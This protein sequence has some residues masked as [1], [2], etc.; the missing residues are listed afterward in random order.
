MSVTQTNDWPTARRLTACMM[1]CPN[2]RLQKR[3]CPGGGGGCLVRAQRLARRTSAQLCPSP[4]AAPTG[5]AASSAGGKNKRGRDP[6]KRSHCAAGGPYWESLVSIAHV[7]LGTF[8]FVVVRCT[9]ELGRVRLWFWFRVE[10][11]WSASAYQSLIVCPAPVPYRQ[12]GRRLV[13]GGRAD[14]VADSRTASHS[15]IAFV[16][17]VRLIRSSVAPVPY[18]Q[19]GRRLVMGGR[20]DGVA[21]SCT[22]SHSAIAFVNRVRLIRSSV[23][24]VPYRQRGH[25]LDD[26]RTCPRARPAAHIFRGQRGSQSPVVPIL[27]WTLGWDPGDQVPYAC[28]AMPPSPARD[29]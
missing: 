9:Y 21:D 19:R 10:A 12:R 15:T 26:G 6:L 13:M 25:R 4:A 7:G 18:R 20:A 24:P 14:G 29:R 11:A 28:L 27:I 3:V 1:S 5:V 16:N 17:R 2:C 23:A 22:A 8:A